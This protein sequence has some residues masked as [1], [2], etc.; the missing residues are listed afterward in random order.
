MS[1]P[2]TILDFLHGILSRR[3]VRTGNWRLG[4]AE[5][6]VLRRRLK[7]PKIK[8]IVGENE[9]RFVP[10]IGCSWWSEKRV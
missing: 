1:V 3:M 4:S 2:G 10:L 9:I 6:G 7:R 5:E 8:I